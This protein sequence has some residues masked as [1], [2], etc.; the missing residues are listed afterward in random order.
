MIR[1]SNFT[2]N[3]VDLSWFQFPQNKQ[4]ILE[5]RT[6]Q[7]H[8]T[9]LMQKHIQKMLSVNSAFLKITNIHKLDKTTPLLQD[10]N[11]RF[12]KL[13]E[14]QPKKINT[15]NKMAFQILQEIQEI[16]SHCEP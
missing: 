15:G 13:Q 16:K 12:S 2:G 11:K 9:N 6:K 3:K 7:G 8:K 14:I 4:K 5:N 10:L 1:F